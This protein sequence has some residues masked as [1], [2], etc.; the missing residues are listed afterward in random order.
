MCVTSAK[1][2]S[3]PH[4]SMCTIKRLWSET[5][6]SGFG[7]FRA[8]FYDFLQNGPPHSTA[9]TDTTK[10]SAGHSFHEAQPPKKKCGQRRLPSNTYPEPWLFLESVQ[11][12]TDDICPSCCVLRVHVECKD[13]FK[14]KLIA[15]KMIY[16]QLFQQLSGKQRYNCY[17]CSN[18][19]INYLIK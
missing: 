9:R 13:F 1:T 14:E 19:C 17:N 6:G 5:V 15:F 18:C 16:C 7:L 12:Q 8:A 4:L 10:P 3:S 11:V 2:S